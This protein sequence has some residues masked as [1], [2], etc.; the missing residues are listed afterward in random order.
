MTFND[1]RMQIPYISFS[2]K[3]VALVEEGNLIHMVTCTSHLN[4]NAIL[5]D[6]KNAVKILLRLAQLN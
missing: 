6:K 2:E 4:K 1:F 5:L 3:A